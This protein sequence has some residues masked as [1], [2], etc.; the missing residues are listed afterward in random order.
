MDHHVYR[1]TASAETRTS[2]HAKSTKRSDGAPAITRARRANRRPVKR[3][4]RDA[5]DD[6]SVD[7]VGLKA[8]EEALQRDVTV[9]GDVRYAHA[10]G[11]PGV[12]RWGQ[13][14]GSIYF[15]DQKV[16]ISVPR[17]YKAAAEA[18]LLQETCT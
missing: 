10:E 14:R 5:R 9:L 7:S 4:H 18:V 8:V 6:L 11:T 17:E 15:A 12:A 3:L 16:P 13:Q 2:A 1:H